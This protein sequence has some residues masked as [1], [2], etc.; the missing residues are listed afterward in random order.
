MMPGRRYITPPQEE[1]ESEERINKR[2]RLTDVLLIV[3]GFLFAGFSNIFTGTKD[4]ISNHD[5]LLGFSIFTFLFS[6][7]SM[8][9][10]SVITKKAEDKGNIMFAISFTLMIVLFFIPYGILSNASIWY[11]TYNFLLISLFSG[12]LLLAYDDKFREEID[13]LFINLSTDFKSNIKWKNIRYI[14]VFASIYLPFIGTLYFSVIS[15]IIEL[16]LFLILIGLIIM[17]HFKKESIIMHL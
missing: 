4:T 1:K 11:S 3:T 7:I 5:L 10:S 12:I 9:V 13:E 16:F 15:P 17:L 14:I 8:Y 2:N 6:A